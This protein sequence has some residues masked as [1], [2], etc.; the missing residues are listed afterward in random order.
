MTAAGAPRAGPGAQCL[1]PTLSVL[2]M[3][4]VQVDR[5]AVGLPEALATIPA[6]IW[7]IPSVGPHVAGQLNG[8]GKHSVAVLACVHFSWKHT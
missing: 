2:T 5:E 8:L 7:L 6:D 3:K 4:G 1:T